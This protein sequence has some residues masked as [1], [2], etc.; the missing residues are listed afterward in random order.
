MIEEIEARILVLEEINAR[1]VDIDG[2][3]AMHSPELD[4]LI[5]ILGS[6]NY[7]YI[8]GSTG[9]S[10]HIAILYD[11]RHVRLNAQCER[12]IPEEEEF[13]KSLFDR[14][15][16]FAHFT[17]LHQGQPMNDLVVVGVHLASGQ[18]RTR[19]HDRAMELLVAT[20]G[21]ARGDEWCIPSDEN[22]IMIT[23]DFNANRFDNEQEEF[24]GKMEG[25][26]WDVL[27]DDGG[28]YP[29]TRLS[30][31]PLGLRNSKIDYVIVTQGGGG[32]QARKSRPAK[33][34]STRI[35]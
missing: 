29:A 2:Q 3:E 1:E 21:E 24:W 22:D 34:W 7:D 32:C 35:S 14:Q 8:V 28:T 30:G 19:N 11:R 13:S 6:D 25:D 16:F 26:G 12:D 17:L 33:P 20:L 4:R 23:R 31:H 27:G 9:G 15:P 10:Q 18:Q 5:G